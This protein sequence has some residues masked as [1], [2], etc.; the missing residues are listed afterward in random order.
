MPPTP[1]AAVYVF[2][3]V[4]PLAKLEDYICSFGPADANP[5]FLL[6]LTEHPL[7][8]GMDYVAILADIALPLLMAGHQR[9]VGQVLQELGLLDL[10]PPPPIQ[11]FAGGRIAYDFTSV[12]LGR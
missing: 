9:D 11:V 4:W 2:T 8:A 7:L 6:A 1:E 12:C 5:D 10:P 3:E